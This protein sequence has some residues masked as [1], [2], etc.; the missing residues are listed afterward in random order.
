MNKLLLTILILLTVFGCDD[1]DRRTTTNIQASNFL[2]DAASFNLEAVTSLFKTKN[3][4]DLDSLEK[5]INNP[6][7][8]INNVDI[9]K[10]GKIDYVAAQEIQDGAT[11]TVNFVAYPS[12]KNGS[13]PTTVASVKL[14][15]NQQT[16]E[17]I[18]EGGYP[19]HVYG[20]DTSYYRY[21]V[22]HGHVSDMLLLSWM[23]SPRPVYFLR[24]Y[25]YYSPLYVSRPVLSSHAV[26]SYRTNYY[27]TSKVSPIAKVALPSNYHPPAV[28]VPSGY[29]AP[30]KAN[31]VG[32]ASGMKNY[33]TRGG[34]QN[35]ASGFGGKPSTPTYKP[36][37]PTRS[38]PISRPST[39]SFSPRRR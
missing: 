21:S 1:R 31:T 11:K 32:G 20:Y 35:P 9:D 19:S 33:T 6:T 38:A 17:V 10:D 26:S 2:M 39:P 27:S 3:V 36:S 8:G 15:V 29:T 34:T 25:S 18:V 28:K 7:S 14:T 4:S 5:E 13:D 24:P 22:H 37:A 12:S 23:L 30:S 16:N